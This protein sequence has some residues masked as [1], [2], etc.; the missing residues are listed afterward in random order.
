M[1]NRREFLTLAASGAITMVGSTTLPFIAHPYAYASQTSQSQGDADLIINMASR[2]GRIPILSG[3][4]TGV[5]KYSAEII[6]G[7]PGSIIN[8]G[9]ESYLGPI[10]RAKKGQR[11][12]IIF[13]NDLPASSIIHWHGLH[14]PE[15]MDGHP[16]FAV[17]AGGQ[18]VYDFTVQDRA[19]TY[20]YHPHPHGKT[21]YQ[22]YGGMAGLFLVYDEHE[23]KLDLPSG[24]YE[25]PLVI[26]DRMFNADNQLV[27]LPGG[28]MNQMTGMMGDSVLVNGMPDYNINAS[29]NAYRFRILNG[30]N[31]R[32]YKLAWSDG[33]PLTIIGTDGGLLPKPVHKPS[34]IIGPG[35]RLDV[36]ADFSQYAVGDNL[37]LVSKF[38]ENG[39]TNMMGGGHMGRGM[40]GGGNIPPDGTPFNI[41]QVRIT[42]KEEKSKT[43]P[44]RLTDEDAVTLNDVLN[45][46]TPRKFELGMF[47]MHGTINGRTFKMTDVAD[48]EIVAAGTSEFWEFHNPIQRRGMMGLQVSHPMHLHGAHFRVL[49]RTGSSMNGYVD[50]GWKDTVMLMPGEHVKLHVRFG[51]NPGLFLYHCHNLEHGDAGMMRNFLIRGNP[52]STAGTSAT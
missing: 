51:N 47:H 24:N 46:G 2:P 50:E 29:T 5:W 36:W 43:L 20:W 27:Y 6:K 40:M 22:V 4:K 13:Q 28:M 37:H 11:I 23:K 45:P 25:M 48:D 41:M 34:A 26:Q 18:Y 49:E 14:V 21:G 8:M 32:T 16:R 52:A 30:S 10:I 1:I 17:P 33:M 9:D 38:F 42:K 7:D 19:G 3:P 44:D 31:A 35:E 12:Q 39:A 15:D